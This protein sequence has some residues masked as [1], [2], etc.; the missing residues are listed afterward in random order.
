MNLIDKRAI[1]LIDDLPAVARTQL[2][3]GPIPRE[4][5]RGGRYEANCRA[6]VALARI[7]FMDDWDR[8]MTFGYSRSD[9]QRIATWLWNWHHCYDLSGGGRW[10]DFGNCPEGYRRCLVLYRAAGWNG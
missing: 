10:F 1:R 6:C 5:E 2:A 7:V 4:E 3:M 8:A 9:T